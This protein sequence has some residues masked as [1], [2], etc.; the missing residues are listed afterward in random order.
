MVIKTKKLEPVS[1]EI[2]VI[3]SDLLMTLLNLDYAAEIGNGSCGIKDTYTPLFKKVRA[4]GLNEN[5]AD[6]LVKVVWWY[7]HKELLAEKT[8]FKEGQY[9]QLRK[10]AGTMDVD[11][12]LD[13]ILKEKGI[14]EF[15]I[16]NYLNAQY[17]EIRDGT[18]CIFK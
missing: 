18:I 8:D 9:Y 2:R 7:A 6:K 12:T 5:K 14:L 13:A 4:R 17:I 11:K 1:R 15:A 16:S 10:E 3:L